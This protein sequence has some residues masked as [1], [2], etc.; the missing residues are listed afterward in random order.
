MDR[1][2]AQP[3]R[4]SIEALRLTSQR[5]PALIVNCGGNSHQGR[6]LLDSRG[7]LSVRRVTEKGEPS[8]AKSKR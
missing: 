8:W 7:E 3:S 1:G 4:T 6:T 5:L 2:T